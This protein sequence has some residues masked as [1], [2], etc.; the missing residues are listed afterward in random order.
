MRPQISS[1]PSSPPTALPEIPSPVFPDLAASLH[2]R[3]SPMSPP[4]SKTVCPWCTHIPPTHTIS[5]LSLR[6]LTAPATS[7]T[8]QQLAA[9][10]DAF[11]TFITRLANDGITPQNTPFV[12]I[13]LCERSS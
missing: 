1:H 12:V 9:Y 4:C 5:I 3:R 13:C 6:A 2:T 10:D 7:A 8:P 11:N